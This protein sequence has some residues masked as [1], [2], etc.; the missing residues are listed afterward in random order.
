MNN[1]FDDLKISESNAT[2]P[3]TLAKTNKVSLNPCQDNMKRDKPDVLNASNK[4]NAID[5][6]AKQKKEV[7]SSKIDTS[8][9]FAVY[10]FV[11]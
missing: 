9:E 4:T 6:S 11:I 8:T 10:L 5:K 3:F 1:K 7:I 2:T